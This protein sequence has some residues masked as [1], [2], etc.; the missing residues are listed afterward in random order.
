MQGISLTNMVAKEQGLIMWYTTSDCIIQVDYI[1]HNALLYNYVP[2]KTICLVIFWTTT[3][4]FLVNRC[5][6]ILL[7]TIRKDSSIQ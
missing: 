7:P 2:T 4:T 5:E 1:K 6:M 3:A